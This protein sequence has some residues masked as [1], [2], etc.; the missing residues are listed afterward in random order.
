LLSQLDDF[1]PTG[2]GVNDMAQL[3]TE[4]KLAADLTELEAVFAKQEGNTEAN[5]EKSEKELKLYS[6][7]MWSIEAQRRLVEM[8]EHLSEIQSD[9]VVD[10]R[11][12][13]ATLHVWEF[14]ELAHECEA[15]NNSYIS[16]DPFL[17]E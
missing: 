9:G 6:H 4:L 3:I 5:I 11:I 15:T 8:K 2:F 10:Q 1:S 17:A 13:E 12:A 14:I 16:H 7:T